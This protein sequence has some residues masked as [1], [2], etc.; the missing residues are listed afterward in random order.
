MLARHGG[1]VVGTYV[2]AGTHVVVRHLDRGQSVATLEQAPNQ[3]DAGAMLF[4]N[5]TN[6]AVD[7]FVTKLAGDKGDDAWY[8][9]AAGATEHWSRVGYEVLAV[10]HADG[11]RLGTPVALGMKVV[12][13][14]AQ[15]KACSIRTRSVQPGMTCTMPPQMWSRLPYPM[16]A[17]PDNYVPKPWQEFFCQ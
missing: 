16:W 15:P 17:Y 10:R 7:V 2:E 6:A 14:S 13:H 4:H 3:A 8:T 5:A 11:S 9:V 1:R 12:L